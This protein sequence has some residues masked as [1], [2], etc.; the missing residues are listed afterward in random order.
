MNHLYLI[1]E[2]DGDTQVLVKRAFLKAGLDV[3]IQFVNDGTETLDYLFGKGR[4]K[5][6]SEFPFPAIL[7]LDFSMPRM[8][9]LEVIKAIRSDSS[10]LKRLVVVMFSSTV[11]ES[12]I[13]KMYEAGV[14][15]Y[16]EKPSDFN[17]LVHAVACIHQYWFGCNHFPY[18]S[19]TGIVRPNKK[20]RP[21]VR[22]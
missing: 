7:L 12:Q 14:N 1:A 10:A 6:R 20:H 18:C 3:P 22:T 4:F 5:D 11:D 17:E 2:D 8:N 16:V 21:P 9:G 15:S 19:P 13:E